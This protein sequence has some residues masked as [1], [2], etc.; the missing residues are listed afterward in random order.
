VHEA[1]YHNI[2]PHD[3]RKRHESNPEVHGRAKSFSELAGGKGIGCGELC[4]S[5][6]ICDLLDVCSVRCG[7]Q[8]WSLWSADITNEKV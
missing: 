1:P 5:Y 2:K 3:N 8:R 6:N 4:N 7:E